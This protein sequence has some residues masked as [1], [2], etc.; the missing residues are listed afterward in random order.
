MAGTIRVPKSIINGRTGP[1]R[2]Y[3]FSRFSLEDFRLIKN[4]YEGT[5]NDAVLAVIAGGLRHYLLRH[6]VNPDNPREVIQALCPVSIRDQTER[7]ALG[8]R[9]AMLLVKLPIDEA[10][11]DLRMVRVRTVV[12]RLKA[13]KQ[14][15]GADFLLNL[16]GFAPA[17]LHAM[18]ARGSLRSIGFNLVVT[19]VP[20]PQFPLYCRGA[21]LVE[22]FPIAFLSEGQ[23][24]AVAIFSYLGYLNFGYLA[25]AT[26]LP[27][28]TVVA[29]CV[30]KGF[31]ELLTAARKRE[32]AGDIVPLPSVARAAKRARA[33]TAPP[34]RKRRSA[35]RA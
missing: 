23:L 32:G 27:D 25:D 26:G 6:D 22:A 11:A 7:T 2:S 3:A 10:N 9:L 8:N 14:A 19:N 34:A 12:D 15:V 16:A 5:I 28:I 21:R 29:R 4:A 31:N 1:S 35:A 13:R 33:K 20:G 18:V 30:E 17:T 24:L